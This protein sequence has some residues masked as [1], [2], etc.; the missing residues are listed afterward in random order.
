[1]S[2]IPTRAPSIGAA[3][4]RGF[5]LYKENF[6]VV[7]LGTL[8]TF[9]VGAVACGLLVPVLAVGLNVVILRLM[10]GEEP[11]PA[12]GDVFSQFSKFWPA[13]LSSL[14]I[15]LVSFLVQAV[16]AFILA[17]IP[18]IGIGIVA[19][20]VISFAFGAVSSWAFLIIADKGAKTGEAIGSIKLIFSG[21]PFWT[22]VLVVLISGIVGALGAI[23]CG[24]GV[25]FTLPLSVCV[26]VAAYEQ[27]GVAAV[28]DGAPAPGETPQEVVG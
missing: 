24:I 22:F 2:Y 6:N 26:N 10:R 7:F 18:V 13:L 19:S 21:K 28:D 5:K 14:V 25:F 27:M 17:F 8:L 9:L 16:L 11:K 20:Y 4:D 15:G 12:A 3:F 23:A 1:M